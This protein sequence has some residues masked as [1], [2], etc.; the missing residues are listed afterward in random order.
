MF[1]ATDATPGES[2][3]RAKCQ[4]SQARGGDKPPKQ[5]KREGWAKRAYVHYVLLNPSFLSR[6]SRAETGS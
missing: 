4:D 6:C 3:V 2:V 5:T 1:N